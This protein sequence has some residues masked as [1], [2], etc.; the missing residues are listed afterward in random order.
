MLNCQLVKF[1]PIIPLWFW[2]VL[3]FV[4]FQVLVSN[5]LAN[6]LPVLI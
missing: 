4:K 3:K 5:S 1:K 2:P 6:D